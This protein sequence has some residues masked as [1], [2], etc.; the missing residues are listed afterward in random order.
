MGIL[1]P[2]EVGTVYLKTLRRASFNCVLRFLEFCSAIII[3]SE[4]MKETVFM[5]SAAAERTKKRMPS[6]FELETTAFDI[7]YEWLT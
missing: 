2:V 7:C 1:N 3:Q 5:G 4:D 6:R